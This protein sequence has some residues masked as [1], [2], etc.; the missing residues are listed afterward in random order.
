MHFGMFSRSRS[1]ARR[2]AGGGVEKWIVPMLA[3]TRAILSTSQIAVSRSRLYAFAFESILLCNAQQDITYEIGRVSTKMH[4]KAPCVPEH[5]GVSENDCT[6]RLAD[7]GA[8]EDGFAAVA[9]RAHCPV[10]TL[11]CG[12]K[13]GKGPSK[14]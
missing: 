13:E 11:V 5:T 4:L 6:E 7:A 12:S 9:K 14:C 10:A 2:A 1:T 8:R 3:N